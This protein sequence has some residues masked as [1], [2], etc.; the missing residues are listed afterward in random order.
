MNIE[1]A[2]ELLNAINKHYCG[3]HS[4]IVIVTKAG[5]RFLIETD[6]YHIFD[7]AQCL[8]FNEQIFIPLESI[9]CI[10][11]DKGDELR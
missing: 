9:D 4:D 1:H 11:S 8:V 3:E 6:R 7:Q 5:A 10:Y 2:R